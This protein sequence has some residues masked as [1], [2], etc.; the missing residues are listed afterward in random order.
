[1]TGPDLNNPSKRD[2][3]VMSR[4]LVLAADRLASI[5]Y[6]NRDTRR[7]DGID[8]SLAAGIYDDVALALRAW[9][10]NVIAHASIDAP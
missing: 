8:E 10:D 2:R 4:T 7:G 3:L 6:S 1:M 9:A 5:A